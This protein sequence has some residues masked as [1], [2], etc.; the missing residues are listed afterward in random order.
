MFQRAPSFTLLPSADGNFVMLNSSCYSV[1]S[2]LNKVVVFQFNGPIYFA[3]NALFKK[4][5]IAAVNAATNLKLSGNECE[6]KPADDIVMKD[7][8]SCINHQDESGD[9]HETSNCADVDRNDTDT[10]DV[11]VDIS[12]ADEADNDEKVNEPLN[13]QSNSDKC[14]FVIINC[15]CVSFVDSAAAKMIAQLHEHYQKSDIRLVL[16]CCTD[17]VLIQL[18]KV[19]QCRSLWNDSIFPSVQDALVALRTPI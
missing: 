11:D 16:A 17:N 3:T 13:R 9:K 18:K 2:S 1:V 4:R 6:Q 19:P 7:A 14:Q 10:A 12:K 5:L 8:S 15:S